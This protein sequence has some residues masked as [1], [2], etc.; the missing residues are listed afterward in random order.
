[1]STDGVY[2]Q[3]KGTKINLDRV[4]FIFAG[5]FSSHMGDKLKN[6]D[7]GSKDLDAGFVKLEKKEKEVPTL[8][9]EDLINA[10]LMPELVGRM[11]SVI[12]LSGLTEGD[13]RMIIDNENI[14]LRAQQKALEELYKTK[15]EI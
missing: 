1:H 2:N 7:V 5:A 12:A 10:G 6:A 14:G 3:S 15:I 11:G 9:S 8:S 4:T 13:L